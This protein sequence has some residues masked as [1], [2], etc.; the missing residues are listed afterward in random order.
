MRVANILNSKGS[1]V[2]TV[3]PSDTVETVAKRLCQ[4]GVGAMVVNDENGFLEG[5]ITEREISTALAIYG[6]EFWALPVSALMG[7]TV[8]TCA[9][10]DRITDIAK[11]MTRRRLRH[12]PVKEDGRVVGIVSIGDVLKYRL[13]EMELESNVLRDMAIAHR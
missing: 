10:E 12:L 1:E 4:E 5:I 6:K 2:F 8:Q 3:H 7:T 13:D 9:S 11:T